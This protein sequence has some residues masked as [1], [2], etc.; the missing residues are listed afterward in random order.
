MFEEPSYIGFGHKGGDF[1]KV[2][3]NVMSGMTRRV[4]HDV[5]SVEF[6]F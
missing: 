5:D 2:A 6:V 4:F 3:I 1:N